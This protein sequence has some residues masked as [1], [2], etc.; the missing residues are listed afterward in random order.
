MS[1]YAEVPKQSIQLKCTLYTTEFSVNLKDHSLD[2]KVYDMYD[3][4]AISQAAH[5]LGTLAAKEKNINKSHQAVRLQSGKP[6]I[7]LGGI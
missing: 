6:G 5:V 3:L 2:C 1:S 7:D 4:G